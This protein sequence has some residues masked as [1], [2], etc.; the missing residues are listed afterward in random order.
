MFLLDIGSLSQE[1]PSISEMCY[2]F[3]GDDQV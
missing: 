2:E 3:M 1:S